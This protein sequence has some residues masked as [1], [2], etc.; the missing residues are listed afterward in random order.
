MKIDSLFCVRTKRLRVSCSGLG[1]NRARRGMR[2]FAITALTLLA[3]AGWPQIAHSEEAVSSTSA[4]STESSSST[5][6]VSTGS[7]TDLSA[8]P[9]ST[10]PGAVSNAPSSATAVQDTGHGAGVF[11]PTPIKF[12]ANIFGGYDDNVNTTFGTKQGSS[13][14]GGNIIAD[15]TFGDPRL[16][17]VMNGGAGGVYYLESVSGQNYDIDLKGALGITYKASPRL[18][19]GG[20]LLLDY[21]TEP[22]FD[23][24]GGLN[25]RNGNYFY[26][27]D[28]FF[29][30]YAWSRRFS[31]RTSY[32]IEAY[33]YE[34]QPIAVFSD[35]VGQIFGN[36]FQF[37]MVPTTALVLEYRF[38][39]INYTNEGDIIIP[40]QFNGLGMQIVPPVRLENDSTTHFVLGGLDHT[41]NPRFTASL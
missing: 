36:A 2:Q 24:P 7:T 16:Q 3:I 30:N 18:T 41:F 4:S 39:L 29:V 5:A 14:S 33:K 1:S 17:V 10:T 38:Q 20:T 32:G 8:G 27:T 9:S 34:N 23:N 6:P 13:Y 28:T 37:Q 31:T 26:T 15:Y 40:A 25:S 11:S 21:L 22:N 19:L 12:Y 35:R